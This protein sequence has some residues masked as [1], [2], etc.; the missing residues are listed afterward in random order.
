VCRAPS[1]VYRSLFRLCR[2]WTP[3]LRG[4][5][6]ASLN[7]AFRRPD[8]TGSSSTHLMPTLLAE[9]NSPGNRS[10]VRNDYN[11]RSSAML[12]LILILGGAVLLTIGTLLP[13][14]VFA[15][16]EGQMTL[17]YQGVDRRYMLRKVSDNTGPLPVVVALHG[18]NQ[19]VEDLRGSWT[20]DAVAGREGFH[21][22]YPE[23]L[24]GRWAYMDSRPVALPSGELVDDVGFILSLLDELTKERVIDPAHVY[25]AGASNGC[26][27]AWTLACAASDR[28]AG[29]APLITGM[30]ERQAEQCHGIKQR[31]QRTFFGP[32]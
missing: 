3:A 20:M 32:G 13:T 8:L 21:V 22:L 10:W 17:V 15:Q 30:I 29:V 6:A 14:E 27:M 18:L 24:A 12:R 26:L 4:Q 16:A 23:A 31:G 9:T 1:G 2:R 7:R 28:F 19:P 11:V 25:V 5:A